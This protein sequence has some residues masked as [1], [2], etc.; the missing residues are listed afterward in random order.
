LTG[1]KRILPDVASL[2]GGVVAGGSS[3]SDSALRAVVRAFTPG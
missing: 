3:V 2:R 1:T